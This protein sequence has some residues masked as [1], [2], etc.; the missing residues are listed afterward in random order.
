MKLNIASIR[1]RD[2]ARF[3]VLNR[4]DVAA[5]RKSRQGGDG[6]ANRGKSLQDWI[7][8]SNRRH[9]VYL[10]RIP[11]GAKWIGPSK[12]INVPSPCD[13]IGVM[14][15][16]CLAFDAKQCKLKT[17]FPVGNRDHFPLHQRRML[18]NFG[19]AGA[20][21]GLMVEHVDAGRLLWMPWQLILLDEASMKW[22]DPRWLAI[23]PSNELID[24]RKIAEVRT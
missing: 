18:V 4:G 7:D 8:L 15:G 2:P 24:W 11:S 10:E 21:A 16:K 3:A 20:V 9:G 1:A 19:E 23:G 5:K 17:N 12:F 14:G 6:L 13:Y 22:E